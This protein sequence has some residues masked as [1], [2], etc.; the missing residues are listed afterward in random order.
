MRLYADELCREKESPAHRE[1]ATDRLLDHYGATAIAADS[2]LLHGARP[3]PRF[4]DRA[5]ALAWLDAEHPNLFAAVLAAPALNRPRAQLALYG[6]LSAYLAF[7]RRLG[8]NADLA[9]AAIRTVRGSRDPALRGLE[10]PLLTELGNALRE[11]RRFDEALDAH[12]KALKRS[13]GDRVAE[14]GALSNLGLTYEQM[15]RPAEAVDVL[16]EALAVCPDGAA[17]RLRGMIHANLGLALQA[18]RRLPEAADALRTDIAICRSLDDRPGE[19]VSLN[20]LGLVLRDQG[21][22]AESAQTFRTALD[23]AR[24]VDDRFTAALAQANLT[25]ATAL[26][27]DPA[28]GGPDVDAIGGALSALDTM[29]DAHMVAQV[30]VDL[31]PV[32]LRSGQPAEAVAVLTAALETAREQHDPR[33]Q[34]LALANLGLAREELGD[35]EAAVRDDTEAVRLFHEIGERFLEA[36]ALV[37]LGLLLRRTGPADAA[38]RAFADAAETFRELG[39][40]EAED[41]ARRLLAQAREQ[42]GH[43]STR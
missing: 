14:A 31:G 5:A 20:N 41:R 25:L 36:R 1:A 27:A 16:E 8:D 35:D 28:G 2:H 15:R 21:R 9:E 26:A 10:T 33:T 22:H 6:P 40:Q 4:A 24:E 12:R 30:R 7:R 42:G 13:R 18:L 19:A 34:A 17:P 29:G 37:N 3:L 39:D 38:C 23:L 32:L 11:L 43:R